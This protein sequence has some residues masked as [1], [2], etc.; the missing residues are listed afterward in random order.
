MYATKVLDAGSRS[1]MNNQDTSIDTDLIYSVAQADEIALLKGEL[2]ELR[3][4]RQRER[5]TIQC[6]IDSSPGILWTMDRTGLPTILSKASRLATNLSWRTIENEGW[7]ALVDESERANAETLWHTNIKKQKQFEVEWTFRQEDGSRAWYLVSLQPIIGGNGDVVRWFGSC[8]NIDAEK[9]LVATLQ[10]S[11]K[12]RSDFVAHI[13]HE[14]RTPL[15][16]IL[17]MIELM[18]RGELNDETRTHALTLKEAGNSLLII[19]NDILD[20]SKLEAGKIQAAKTDFNLVTIVE[21]VAQI[22]TPAA[23]AKNLLILSSVDSAAPQNVVGD[24]QRLRQVLLNLSSNAIKFTDHGQVIIRVSLSEP[25]G[26]KPGLTFTISDTGPGLSEDMMEQLFEPFFQ[27][28]GEAFRNKAGTGLGLS[29]SKQFVELMGGKIFVKSQLGAGAT[30]GF[31]L[32]LAAG[33]NAN[34]TGVWDAPAVEQRKFDVLTFEPCHQGRWEIGTAFQNVGMYVRSVD[35]IDLAIDLLKGNGRQAP[36]YQFVVV[37]MVRYKMQSKEL[38]KRL[39][40]LSLPTKTIEVVQTQ[41]VVLE[42]T[43]SGSQSRFTLAMPLQRSNMLKCLGAYVGSL[44]RRV[45]RSCATTTLQ[46]NHLLPIAA[47]DRLQKPGQRK[48]AL[49]GDDNEINRR[50]VKLFLADMGFQVDLAFDGVEAVQAFKAKR[51]D[52]V[53][54]DCQM[55]RLDGFGAAKIIKE[56]QAR[57][58][59]AVPVIALTA[60]AVEGTRED[61]LAHDMDDYLSKPIDPEALERLVESWLGSTPKKQM[62]QNT[63]QSLVKQTAESSV[64]LINFNKLKRTFSNS[65]INSILGVYVESCPMVLQELDQLVAAGNF[66]MCE[67]KLNSF[68]DSSETIGATALVMAC[69]EVSI[70]IQRHDAALTTKALAHLTRLFDQLKQ[71][72]TEILADRSTITLPVVHR[73]TK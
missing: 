38:L 71:E 47:A 73:V 13:S 35:N 39:A 43:N 36:K 28:S 52:L 48:I 17:P 56:L 69:G 19:I 63:T 37:D 14:L 50:V 45:D 68:Q 4:R 29:I 18:L 22:L 8:R 46:L 54:L 42:E 60:N 67:R 11:L 2:A 26:G 27:G 30:F 20:F 1:K 55:P 9:S 32:P 41:N 34:I 6:I 23:A 72:V 21:G 12:T 31:S 70:A 65:Q 5:E 64:S 15:N 7:T 51:Y 57:K 25:I 44:E 3:G 16:G 49:V 62:L 59:I 53:F 24:P 61:C 33:T 10:S 40:E 58:G 66:K